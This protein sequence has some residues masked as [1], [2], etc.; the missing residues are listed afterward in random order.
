M[1][2]EETL[3]A[4][5]ASGDEAADAQGMGFTVSQLWCISYGRSVKWCPDTKEVQG[6]TFVRLSKF[7]RALVRFALGKGM[8]M[9]KEVA[10]SANVQMFDVLL[11]L[12][13]K[14]STE[15]AERAMQ[16]D[17]AGSKKQRVTEQ[18]RALVDEVVTLRL[19][20][21]PAADVHPV[22]RGVFECKALWGLQSGDLWIE[23]LPQN[24]VWFRD[25][26]RL[27]QHEKGKTRAQKGDPKKKRT[28]TRKNA[29]QRTHEARYPQSARERIPLRQD[30][31]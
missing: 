19:P 2:E 24:L 8:N 11:N 20:E 21:L 25:M 4:G 26:I 6:H 30:M 28:Y 15:A 9:R 22:S 29:S 31:A 12:R 23:L 3:E 16:M 7:D 14:A 13:R 27:G 10:R 17:E 1:S 5:D 18:H